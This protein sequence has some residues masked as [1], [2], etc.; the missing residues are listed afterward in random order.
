MK[1]LLSVVICL[2]LCSGSP[3]ARL[4]SAA[5]PSKGKNDK[6]VALLPHAQVSQDTIDA[7]GK[8]NDK[9][10]VVRQWDG[11]LYMEASLFYWEGEDRTVS[12]V[13]AIQYPTGGP[14]NPLVAPKPPQLLLFQ[15]RS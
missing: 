3:T 7:A 11:S 14:E 13:L 8:H 4:A 10:F 2:L 9:G 5:V 12:L 15:A 6:K 1:K